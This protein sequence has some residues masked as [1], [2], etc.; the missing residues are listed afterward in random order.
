MHSSSIETFSSFIGV[1][2]V[3]TGFLTSVFDIVISPRSVSINVVSAINATESFTSL[4]FAL[5]EANRRLQNPIAVIQ[6]PRVNIRWWLIARRNNLCALKGFRA[7]IR[8]Q[9]GWFATAMMLIRGSVGIKSHG[10]PKRGHKGESQSVYQTRN[11]SERLRRAQWSVLL[12]EY[13]DG[14]AGWAPGHKLI[15]VIEVTKVI[16]FSKTLLLRLF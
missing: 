15:V 14:C 7:L 4:V 11:T 3:T 6:S 13:G 10:G 12:T 8:V 5:T 1:R 2:F 9:W 16:T